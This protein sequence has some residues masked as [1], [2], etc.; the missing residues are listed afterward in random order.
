MPAADHADDG[1]TGRIL[2]IYGA[3]FA[4]LPGQQPWAQYTIDDDAETLPVPGVQAPLSLPNISF[5]VSTLLP[6]TFHTLSVKVV[7]ATPDA[8]FLFDYIVIGFLD[9]SEDPDP[10]NATSSV[11]SQSSTSAPPSMS[12]PSLTASAASATGSSTAPAVPV[13]PSPAAATFPVAPVIG[14][15]VGGIVALFAVAAV[16]LCVWKHMSRRRDV[17]RESIEPASEP[18][19]P[20]AACQAYT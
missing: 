15:I 8:P 17:D 19:K 13:A 3:A 20:S 16:I 10:P 9:A 7:N 6:L 2:Q 14:A 4:W 11:P 5:Y 18:S 1:H 12:A